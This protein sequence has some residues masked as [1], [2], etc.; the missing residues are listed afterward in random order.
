MPGSSRLS[1]ID[2]IPLISAN[3]IFRMITLLS[4]AAL[5]QCGEKIFAL[6][7]LVLGLEHYILAFIYSR[8]SPNSLM[9]SGKTVSLFS[10][11]TLAGIVLA[12]IKAPIVWLSIFHHNFNEVYMRDSFQFRSDKFRA[13][14]L[15]CF[16]L[17]AFTFLAILR[18]Q[19]IVFNQTFL[20][21]GVFVSFAWYATSLFRRRKEFTVTQLIDNSM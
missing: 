2:H 6:V 11:V 19:A 14:R 16:V 13:L 21:A 17:N 3:T 20:F 1:G 15:S 18:D 10:L 4:I 7:A 8:R 5:C 9:S 12:A